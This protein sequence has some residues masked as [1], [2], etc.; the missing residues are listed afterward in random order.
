M[1]VNSAVTEFNEKEKKKLRS[2]KKGY[3]DAE[4]EKETLY[5]IF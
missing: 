2:I 5:K 4:K 1:G 3:L